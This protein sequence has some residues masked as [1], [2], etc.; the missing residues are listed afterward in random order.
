MKSPSPLP[1][2]LGIIG[3][4]FSGALVLA[5]VVQQAK[6]PLIIEWFDQSSGFAT[7]VAYS[8]KEARHLLNVRVHNMGAFSGHPEGFCQWL[9]SQE[10]REKTEQLWP[11]HPL[12]EESFA[13]RLLYGA[14][15]Q[16]I[17]KE[18]LALA[19]EK[20]I[21][22]RLHASAV[23][24][25]HLHEATAKLDLHLTEEGHGAKI[26]VDILVLATGNLL[27]KTNGFKS[28]LTTK[29]GLSPIKGWGA[30]SNGLSPSHLKQLS[31]DDNIFIL[32]TG[33]TTVDSLLTLDKNGF[34]GTVTALSRH[35][36]LPSVHALAKPYH[37]WKWTSNPDQAPHTVLA[38]LQELRQEIRH[39][40]KEG[41]DWRSVID[42]LRSLTPTLWKRLNVT[43]KRKFMRR[44]STLWSIHRHR[45]APEIDDALNA[46]KQ[47]DRLRIIAGHI[48]HIDEDGAEFTITYRPHH[49][50]DSRT[51]RAKRIL[52]CTGPS[53]NIATSS[54]PLLRS[55]VD[56]KIVQT[57]AL[58]ISLLTTVTRA[59]ISPHAD[60]IYPIGNL[61]MGELLECTAVPELRDHAH[62]IAASITARLR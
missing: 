42:S 40:V 54:S 62:E 26:P 41:Y 14:Y 15:L 5:N 39:A 27:P 16:A 30:E 44:L 32:G 20:K 22:I 1:S 43:E 48:E 13:P 49:S 59:A 25:A 23:V 36:W 4:G 53:Y 10:G 29:L 2:I 58:G 35:G 8:T 24:D 33:L 21:D 12:T 60:M 45:M 38:M 3:G 6:K 50:H 52:D 51:T 7:G 61:R 47:K 34:K 37:A 56:Q 46:M 18:T 19:L 28:P 57:D 55:L 9:H 31:E 17:V 11:G